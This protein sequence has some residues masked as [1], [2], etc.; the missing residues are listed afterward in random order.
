MCLVGLTCLLVLLPHDLLMFGLISNHLEKYPFLYLKGHLL[1]V[2]ISPTKEVDG[3][4]Y[5]L[6]V[7]DGHKPTCKCKINPIIK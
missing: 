3:Y 7:L 1:S 6:A 5:N 4:Y 2:I